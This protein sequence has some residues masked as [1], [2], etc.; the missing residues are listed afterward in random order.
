MDGVI[1]VLP[2]ELALVA[3]ATAEPTAFAVIYD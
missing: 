3:E 1:A 2:N